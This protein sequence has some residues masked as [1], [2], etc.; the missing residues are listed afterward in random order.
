MRRS[1]C[2][3]CGN[4]NREHLLIDRPGKRR[5]M[6]GIAGLLGSANNECLADLSTGL[7]HRGPDGQGIWLDEQERVGFAHRRLSIIDLSNAAAQPMVSRDGRYVTTFNGEI[8]NYRVISKMLSGKGYGFNAASDTAV[9]APLYDLKGPDMLHDLEGMFAFS[10]WDR[11]KKRLFLARDHTGI[12]PLYYSLSSGR[13]I[14]ASELKAICRILSSI[15]VDTDALKE[16]LTFLWTPGERT[17]VQQIRKLRPG[18]YLT[19][20][21]REGLHTEIRRW[22]RPPQAPL[23]GGRP[24]YD[25]SKTPEGLRSLLDD[26]VSDQCTSDVPI[27]AFLSG[28]VDSSAVVASMVAT[29]HRP[30]RTYCV[31]TSGRNASNE[32]FDEDFPFAERV[33]RHLNVP[34]TRVTLDED[35]ILDGLPDLPLLLDEPTAD[36]AALLVEAI[37]KHARADGVKVL[38]T[39][40]GGDDIFSGYRRHLTARLRERFGAWPRI[41][42]AGAGAAR[43]LPDGATRRRFEKLLGLIGHADSDTFLL[44]AFNQNSLPNALGL[45]KGASEGITD[46]AFDNAL[47]SGLEETKGQNLLNRLLYLE[48]CGFLPDHNLNYTD[49]ACMIAGVEARVP[50]IDPRLIDFMSDVDP[51]LKIKGLEPKWF[52]KQAVAARLPSEVLTRRK[53]GFGAPVR[54]LCTAG[55]GRELIEAALFSNSMVKDNFDQEKLRI[56]WDR[57]LSGRSDGV[58]LALTIAMTG[59]LWEALRATGLRDS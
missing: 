7:A 34:L 48:M 17:L 57:T 21:F 6:C 52:F 35:A 43:L 40:T 15:T 49:K 14:F 39:G 24:G 29:G 1:H 44:N 13:L 53:V 10:I 3:D 20:E 18:H 22:Y 54:R 11:Q 4:L 47:T 9:L 30:T 46:A 28:G 42:Q 38:L 26:V 2:I 27:G 33:A 50:L 19:A 41:A 12:K 36:P 16:Y 58:Y 45:L 23:I 55:R 25:H 37:A 5:R 31:D 8:F 32:G 56:F 51:R 59:W